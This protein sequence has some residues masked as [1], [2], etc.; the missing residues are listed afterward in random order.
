MVRYAVVYLA[1]LL[2][3]GLLDALWLGVIAKS[4]Y[5]EGMGDL[6]APKINIYAAAAFYLLYP[7][8][9]VIFAVLPS[10]DQLGKAVLMG[11]LFGLFC[12]GTYD[13]TNLAV[14]RNWP[15]GLSFLDIAW[16][17]TVSA[18]GATAGLL[19]SRWMNN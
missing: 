16:G 17:M 4:W 15:V 12:Y 9:V 14:V 7:V 3:I 8:G 6:L 10:G 11:A 2:V 13:M 19:A 18:A 5:A 1:T